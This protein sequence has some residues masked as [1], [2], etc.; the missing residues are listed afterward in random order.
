[1]SIDTDWDHEAARRRGYEDPAERLRDMELDGI[2]AQVVYSELSAFRLVPWLG[3]GASSALRAFNDALA[4]FASA[5]PSRLLVAYQLALHDVPAATREAERLAER[6]ARAVH[7]PNYP[8]D[9]GLA[10]YHDPTY[11]RLWAVLEELEL[12]VHHHLGNKDAMWEVFRRDPT[13]QGGVYNSLNQLAL[14]ENIGFW[15]LSGSLERFPRL[16]VV[17]VESGLSWLP[18]YLDTLDRRASGPF[19]FPA[20][21]DKPSEYFKRQM[22]VTFFDDSL[23]LELRNRIGVGNIMWSS[24]Y[25]HPDTTWPHSRETIERQFSGVPE[26]DANRI[27]FENARQ[28]YGITV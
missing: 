9:L 18:F 4:E 15:I 12:P 13:P 14:A 20:I 5:D 10:D 3:Q 21:A 28:L 24:D 19:D 23:G 27:L 11:D 26:F 16:R 8:S 6:G 17:I 2:H 1:M 22:M 7:I 25:P